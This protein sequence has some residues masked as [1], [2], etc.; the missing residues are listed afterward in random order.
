MSAEVGLRVDDHGFVRVLAIDRPARRNALDSATRTLLISQLDRAGSDPQVRVIVLTGAGDKSFCAGKDLHQLRDRTDAGQGIDLPMRGVERNLYECVLE[1][2]KPTIAALNG[3]AVGGG[4]E[5]AL[6]CDLRVMAE[7]A[8][9][10][11]PEALRG[12]G[13]NAASVLLPQLLPRAV[14]LEML[15]TARPMLADEALRWGLVNAVHP[16]DSLLEE[17]LKL[18]GKIASNAPLTTRRYAEMAYKAWGQPMSTA[19]RLDVG[20]NPY[21][22]SDRKEGVRAYLEKRQPQ[23]RGE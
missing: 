5:L 15:Y 2:Y 1:T 18:A 16:S 8:F 21:M 17:A 7:H 20:P 22:S 10:R 11:L 23:W 6:A 12:M 14:A 13:A 19:L 3:P 4:L 9:L